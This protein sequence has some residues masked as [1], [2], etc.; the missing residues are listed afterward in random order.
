[1]DFSKYGVIQKQKNLK[2]TAKRLNSKLWVTTFRLVIITLV[3][4]VIMLAMVGF[5]SLNAIIDTAPDISMINVAPTGFSSTSYYADGSVAETFAGAEANRVYVTIDEIPEMVRNCFVALEDE[6]FYT[7]HGIDVRGI[8]RA[9]YSVLKTDGLG[10][11]ASTLTQQLLKNQV[12]EGGKEK[13]SVDKITRKLQE[14][15][16]A[17]QLE[18]VLTKDQILE[19]YLNY[20]NLGNGAYGIQTAAK[21]YFGKD[22]WQLTLS[23]ASVIAPIALS[24]TNRNPITH[25]KDNAERRQA[26]L[27]NML[28]YGYCTKAQYDAALRD[29]VYSRVKSIK[30]EQEAE[31]K[32]FSYFTDEL[33]EQVTQD[34]QDRL[35]YTQS[36]AENMIYYGGIEI[37][38]TQDKRI[39]DILDK[40]YTDPDYFPAFGW[41]SSAG[42]CYELTY[43][44]S[45]T[46]DDETV[47]HYQRSDFLNYF[48]DYVDSEH[49][50]YHKNGGTKG[51]SEL[52][53]NTEDM[54]AK[55]EEFRQSVVGPM[56]TYV[57]K[58]EYVPQ[59]QSSFSVIEQST[60]KVVAI[61]GG[62]GEKKQSRTLN[63]ASNTVRQVGS[64]FKVL[65]S[66]LPAIDAGG[67]TLAS[68]QDDCR[69]HYPGGKE[70]INWYGSSF[71]GL[72]SLRT[73]IYQ[74]LNIVAVKTL[75]QIGAPLGFEYLEKLGFTTLVRSKTDDN[76]NV[77]SDINLAIALGGL[78]N[79]V[80]NVELT[81]AYASIA[82]EGV[83]N[84]PIY[85]TKVVDHD[86]KVILSNENNEGSQIMKT[87]TAWLLTSAMLDTVQRGTGSKLAFRN[88]SMPV[89]G[90]T[91]T[92][93]KNNDLWFVGY[94]PYYT[95]AVWTGFD[96]NF[97]Q[98]N[99]SY[100]QTL[101]RSIME[102]IHS[103]LE[104]PYKTWER[105]DSVVSATICTKCG[106]LAVSGLCD[107][108]EGGSC[109]KSEYFAK[110]TVPTEKCTCHIRVNI[111]KKSGKI[112]NAY[113]PADQI[114]SAVFL[115]KDEPYEETTWDTPYILSNHQEVCDIHTAAGE[116][117]PSG[118]KGKKKKDK[119]DDEQGTGE[120]GDDTG[121]QSGGTEGDGGDTGA[122]TGGD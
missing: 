21:S 34:L 12:F 75:Q 85:Y 38:T 13:N 4:G 37:Y 32:P 121:D 2:S 110:G 111:C 119:K 103:T 78:T 109:V 19:Y 100:Q 17:I 26:C 61:Y 59:P 57:E 115:V 116:V 48:K 43:A 118:K 105:P 52:F 42:S 73:G 79:G 60:G 16:L 65:A 50:Y 106:K 14:Q 6:R 41:G 66:F 70:V 51:I 35:G 114:V 63:R 22:V 47:T 95:A 40:Y 91:G 68:V 45:V 72:Q 86:G 25:P 94:T 29:D 102:E 93:S 27:D 120:G 44:I 24:P 64:T 90:K 87:S 15:Y 9:G 76:G 28:E 55:I 69:Y 49:Y 58:L 71:R 108:A 117:D 33:I 81:A 36:Q 67:L 53:L 88:Y 80:S 1:M 104:L 77:Y 83:Y 107:A 89:A 98:I 84:K 62:R 96:N 3:A 122:E 101:W 113:C 82:N 92:A 97:S 11:G 20:I 31:K 112:P 10:F 56:D 18:S 74:S 99:K 7:H 39:Q 30:K 54:D 23:E 5:G 46:H 8:F